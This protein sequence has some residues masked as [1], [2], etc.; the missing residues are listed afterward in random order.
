MID[1]N[2]HCRVDALA[3]N[4]HNLLPYTVRSDLVVCS[5]LL[6]LITRVFGQKRRDLAPHIYPLFLDLTLKCDR[7]QPHQ[8]DVTD[9]SIFFSLTDRLAVVLTL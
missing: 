7:Q 3:Q 9:R 8:Y 6:N 5:V 1:I 2:V 4:R